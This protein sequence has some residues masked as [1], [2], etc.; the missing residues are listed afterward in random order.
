MVQNKKRKT[1]FVQTIYS[2]TNKIKIEKR[3]EKQKF[4]NLCVGKERGSSS[5][6][7]GSKDSRKLVQ[8]FCLGIT[9]RQ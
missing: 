8:P 6:R 2:K 1:T 3:T 4:G 5:D 7:K 9:T